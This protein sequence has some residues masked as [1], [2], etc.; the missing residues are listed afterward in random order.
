M[1][2]GLPPETIAARIHDAL[3][4]PNPKVRYH[5]RAGQDAICAG[6]RA[7]QTTMDKIIAKRLG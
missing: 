5:I 1:R 6:G 7:A 4:L 2:F 3:T